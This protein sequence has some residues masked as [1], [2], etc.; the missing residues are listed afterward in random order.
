[1]Q[2]S[3]VVVDTGAVASTTAMPTPV[4]W[5]SFTKTVIAAEHDV[6]LE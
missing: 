6:E 5:W 4:P 3:L 1:M 2:T